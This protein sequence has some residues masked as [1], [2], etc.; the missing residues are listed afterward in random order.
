MDCS[1]SAEEP[2]TLRYVLILRFAQGFFAFITL[3]L[4]AFAAYV[5]GSNAVCGGLHSNDVHTN[6]GQLAGF[7]LDWF[8]CIWTTAFLLYLF[9]VPRFSQL[10]QWR[11]FSALN[12]GLEIAT[13]F[14]WLVTFSVLAANASRVNDIRA[15][16]QY[17]SETDFEGNCAYGIVD[18]NPYGAK[19]TAAVGSTKAAAGIAALVL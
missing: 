17:C 15:F 16:Y 13:A 7:G 9:F 12:F 8:T 18:G 3:V 5:F 6:I 10:P 1:N 11:Y 19:G 2:Q 4:T 14:W